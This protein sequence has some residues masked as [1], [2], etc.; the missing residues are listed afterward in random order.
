MLLD[1][2]QLL[3]PVAL[4]TTP[5]TNTLAIANATFVQ[6]ASGDV[7][8][9]GGQINNTPTVEAQV[10]RN[11][12]GLW[13]TVGNMHEARL[14]FLMSSGD[15]LVVGGADADKSTLSSAEIYHP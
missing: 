14:G 9:F 15:V 6:L 7:L 5:T 8:A 3:D 12:T 1:S 2:S 11:A 10:Y 4:T 13:T